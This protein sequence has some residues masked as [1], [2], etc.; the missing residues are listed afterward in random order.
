ML[1][2]LVD[3]MLICALKRT[4]SHIFCKHPNLLFVV[5]LIFLVVTSCLH[6][7]VLWIGKLKFDARCSYN[8][9]M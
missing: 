9:K 6:P 1:D 3:I 8:K 2:F 5:L 7:E 4:P